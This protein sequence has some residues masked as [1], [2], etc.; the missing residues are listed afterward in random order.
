MKEI[1][2]KTFGGLTRQY[3]MRHLFFGSLFPAMMISTLFIGDNQ[4]NYQALPVLTINTLLYPYSR[5]VYESV[6]GFI[7]GNNVFFV[8]PMLMLFT[9][10]MTM[11]FCWGLAIF[12]APIGLI[13][14]YYVN[15]KKQTENFGQ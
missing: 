5:F 10:I 9:K 12:V 4:F 3:Y 8:N 15:S 7:I 1:I 6:M 14:L 13:Y 11:V 2:R